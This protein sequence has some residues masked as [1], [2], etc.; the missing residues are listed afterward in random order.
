MVQ[1]HSAEL[2]SMKGLIAQKDEES[3]AMQ[4]QIDSLQR[5]VADRSAQ[6]SGLTMNQKTAQQNPNI[7]VQVLLHA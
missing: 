5:Q 6:V 3:S 2:E 7:A 4:A 1:V